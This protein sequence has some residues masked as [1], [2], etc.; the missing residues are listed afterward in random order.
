[1]NPVVGKDIG[2]WG[3]SE[4]QYALRRAYRIGDSEADYSRPHRCG[5]LDI[6]FSR[7]S[8]HVVYSAGALCHPGRTWLPEMDQLSG[9]FLLFYYY[10][11]RNF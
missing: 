8:L 10:T 4:S 7:C 9:N 6:N 5:L 2:I 11:L 3:S 1:M